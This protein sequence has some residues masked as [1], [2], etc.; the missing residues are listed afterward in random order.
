VHHATASVEHALAGHPIVIE[1]HRFPESVDQ[2]GQSYRE[3]VGIDLAKLP[4]SRAL[5]D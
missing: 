5:L 1:D 4:G 3:I 2:R